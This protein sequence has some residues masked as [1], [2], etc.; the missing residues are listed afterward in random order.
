MADMKTAVA[1]CKPVTV[2]CAKPMC[3]FSVFATS[4]LAPTDMVML[5]SSLSLRMPAPHQ[6]QKGVALPVVLMFLLV[7]TSLAI[8]SARYA[9][10][11]EGMARNQLDAERARQA[12]ESALRDA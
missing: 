4:K 12:A 1:R 5:Q 7:I 10:M 6:P 2:A 8:F 9:T 11:G 3:R